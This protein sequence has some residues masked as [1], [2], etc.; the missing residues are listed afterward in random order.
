[1]AQPATRSQA[2]LSERT[3]FLLD[4]DNT[5]LDNDRFGADLTAKLDELFGIPAR[6]RYW[7]LFQSLR[8]EVGYAD[9][10]GA[11]QRFRSGLDDDPHLLV[12]SGYL[13][14]YPFVELLFPQALE[15]IAHLQRFGRPVI[16]SDGDVVFQPR[17][18]HRSGIWDAVRGN[19]LIYIHKEQV[20]D[21]VQERRPAAH[22][23]MVDDKPHLLA[24]MKRVLGSRLTTVFVRQG[25]YALAP[26]SNEV[27]P[28][29]DR[30]IE[31]IAD[32][33]QTTS[34]NFEV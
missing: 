7:S 5:L 14:E 4:V 11:L 34:E 33:L 29:P 25:H 12:I 19:V 9:Y 27:H 15:V 8:D 13:L 30:I 6:E 1:V 22:Y 3:V 32:L 17:K 31:R 26:G 16:L 20:L 28:A 23:V 10:L 18:I 2:V 24:A 21:H